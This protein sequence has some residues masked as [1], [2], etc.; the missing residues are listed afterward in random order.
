M[1]VMYVL[2]NAREPCSVMRPLLLHQSNIQRLH[3]S[4]VAELLSS[5]LQVYCSLKPLV[6]LSELVAGVYTC[7]GALLA[8]VFQAEA[9]EPFPLTVSHTQ[10]AHTT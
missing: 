6:S 5:M 10:Q 7:A 1:R 3:S 8:A 9:S 2:S 4:L